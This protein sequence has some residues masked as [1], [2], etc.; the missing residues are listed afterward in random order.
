MGLHTMRP[1]RYS[2]VVLGIHYVSRMPDKFFRNIL[3]NQA[4]LMG[5]SKMHAPEGN[6][7][8]ADIVADKMF[9]MFHCRC[10]T[11]F[12]TVESKKLIL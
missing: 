9:L 11:T 5:I 10:V 12:V 8:S 2:Y 7:S 3:P 1:K 6:C 4:P